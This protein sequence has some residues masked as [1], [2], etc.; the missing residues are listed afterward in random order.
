[1]E[2]DTPEKQPSTKN[3]LALIAERLDYI[4]ENT[5]KNKVFVKDIDMPFFSMM[6]FMIKWALAS[7]PA[8]IILFLLGTIGTAFFS[9]ILSGL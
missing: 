5:A 8:L 7:I 2:P 9:G 6:F 4:E 3:V 1:M